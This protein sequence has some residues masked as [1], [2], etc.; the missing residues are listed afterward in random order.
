MIFF[1]DI[2]QCCQFALK[3]V[4]KSKN[5]KRKKGSKIKGQKIK[6]VE[7][8]KGGKTQKSSKKLQTNQLPLEIP[9]LSGDLRF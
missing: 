7:N 2:G 4:S 5:R 9:I 1:S 8:L 3:T 6:R